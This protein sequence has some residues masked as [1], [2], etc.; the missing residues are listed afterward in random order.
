MSDDTD[1]KIGS[2]SCEQTEQC[3]MQTWRDRWASR[4]KMAWAAFVAMCASTVM[5]FYSVPL[6]KLDKLDDVIIWFYGTMTTIILGY[7]GT[8]V[9]AHIFDRRRG[10]GS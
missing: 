5:I 1:D 2:S 4:R 8:T 9:S 7:M 10:Q 6:D 3:D